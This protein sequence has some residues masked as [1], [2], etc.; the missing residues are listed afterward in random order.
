MIWAS[1]DKATAKQKAKAEEKAGVCYA[2]DDLVNG[3]MG[4]VEAIEKVSSD[5]GVSKGSL[6]RWFY[7]V[8]DFERGDWLPIL[9]GNYHIV[10]PI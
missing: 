3:G 6:K 7:K 5:T 2:V 8:R 1:W 4:S 9:L 10:K